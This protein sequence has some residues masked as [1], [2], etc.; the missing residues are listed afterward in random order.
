MLKKKS[1]AV[2]G[3]GIAGLVCA[4]E[5]QEAGFSVEV[6]EAESQVGGR[7]GT[8]KKDGLAFDTGANFFVE[9]YKVVRSLAQELGI[10]FKRIK[11]GK[12]YSVRK[13]RLC[14]LST[15]PKKILLKSQLL[16]F[17]SRLRLLWMFFK[18][19]RLSLNTDFYELS[20]RGQFDNENAYDFTCKLAGKEVA[21]YVVDPFV[22]TYQFHRAKELGV[23]AMFSLAGM[24]L[25]EP[26]GFKMRHVSHE[27]GAI[28]QALARRLKVHVSSPIAGV[29]VVKEG[30]S[31]S[32]GK[33]TRTF[34]FVVLAC[35]AP[36][37][38]LIY[39]NPTK[40]QK[41]LLN[42]VEY[43]ATVNVSFAIPLKSLGDATVV[44]VPYVEGG[45]IAEYTYEAMKGA[46]MIS[47]RETLINVGLHEDFA[48]KIMR[49]SDEFIFET[50]EKELRKV[51][52]SLKG[53]GI[54]PHDLQRWPYAMPKFSAPHLVAICQFLK[55][56]Q[57]E[58]KVYFCGD[59]LNAP[60]VEGAVRCGQTVAKKILEA[61]Q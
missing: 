57:G 31:L 51:C 8:R 34:D 22:S 6:F 12:A 56:G 18:L 14:S 41:E 58:N 35:P 33:K 23:E 36:V 46:E 21:D 52:P 17:R 15:N 10:D 55:Q 38:R 42:L 54:R 24:L 11:E 4:Y 48:R 7:M 25:R 20:T 39:K 43:S 49:K 30:L 19:G 60:W 2:V 61:Q 50:V 9:N 53:V 5:L 26:N 45:A 3:A 40:R 28:P 29:S 59:Y 27:M 1:V 32:L 16:S 47:G 37:S 44:M 13:G